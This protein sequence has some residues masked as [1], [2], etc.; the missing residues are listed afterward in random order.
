MSYIGQGPQ[1]AS[2]PSKFFDG[3]NS[4]MTVTLDYA[5]PNNASLLVFIS[6][7]KQDTSAYTLNGTSLTFTGT[8]PSGTANVQVIHLG[9]LADV[10]V[11]ADDSITSAKIVN[12]AIVD[13]DVNASA[14]IALSKLATDPSN[15]STLASGTVPT[16][17]LGSGS[18]TS[19]TVL[20]GNNTWAA[21]A[22]LP[23]QTDNSGKTLITDGTDASWAPKTNRNFIINGDM[24]IWQR[25]TNKTGITAAGYYTADRWRTGNSSGGTWTQQR[26]TN[27]VLTS[28]GTQLLEMI[29]TSAQAS[30][31][32]GAELKI[33]QRIEGYNLQA[34]K[35]GTANAESITISFWVRASKTGTYILEIEDSDN[36]RHICQA[37]TINVADTFEFKE[38]TFAGDTTGAMTWDSGYGMRLFW[39]LAAGADL[40]SGTL[41]TSWAAYSQGNEAVGQVNLADATTGRFY[42]GLV[43]MEIGAVATTFD[44]DSYEKTLA[45]CQRYYYEISSAFAAVTATTIVPNIQFPVTM[46]A[47]PTVTHEYGG[48]DNDIYQISNG[49]TPTFV[50]NGAFPNADG[51]KYAYDFDA[52]LTVEG[53]Q[54]N[55]TFDAEL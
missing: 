23:T 26:S 46:R 13:A 53:H 55:W 33:A 52:G 44:H 32:S 9:L 6:G 16:A 15:A 20:H 5:P 7:V 12:G 41:A 51:Y 47:V 30:L 19:S 22:S 35:K 14:A 48:V 38:L 37:Y 42:L 8:V 29:C 54:T 31:A 36:S 21:V 11:P 39:F 10:G 2:F 18:A 27:P 24:Q 34:L 17:R 43:K 1:F 28:E 40:Q 50:A 4:A 3:D 45:D 25:A 49:A